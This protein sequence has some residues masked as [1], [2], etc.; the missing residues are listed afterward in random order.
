MSAQDCT[1]VRLLQA[2]GEEFADKGFE[3]ARIRTICERAEANIAAVNYHFGDKEQLYIAAVVDA[4]RCG[5]SLEIGAIGELSTPAQVLREYIHQF[6]GKVL[7][8]QESDDW[9]HRLMLR[10]MLDPTKATEVL[11]R[12]SIQPR[13]EFLK[14]ILRRICPEADERRLTVLGFSVIGQ[15]LHYKMARRFNESLMGVDEFRELDLGYLTDHIAGFCLAALGV[16]SPL[17]RAGE[18]E[19][20]AAVSISRD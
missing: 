7:A 16:A 4:H 20:V 17:N 18:P 19:Q 14:S 9:R 8:I 5:G 15:C 1:R 10:E 11:I 3:L 2:A 13:F 12:E 6:L